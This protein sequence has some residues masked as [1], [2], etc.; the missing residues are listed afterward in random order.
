MIVMNTDTGKMVAQ[1]P[2]GGGADEMFFDAP[3]Q[4]IYLQG[5]EGI[6][7]VWK[8]VD[9]DHYE[10]IGRIQGGVH[11]KTSLLVP[12]LRRYYNAVS[13]QRIS[14]DTVQGSK[15]VQGCIEVYE[16]EP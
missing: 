12:E 8:E 5:Y 2:A 13:Q 11:G 9:P 7:D 3:S 14:V 4:R 6:T 16:V 1:F 15:L 10:S